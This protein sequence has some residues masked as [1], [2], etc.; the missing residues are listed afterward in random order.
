MRRRVVLLIYRMLLRSSSRSFSSRSML[1]S[2]SVS[3]SASMA[4]R[5]PSVSA[6]RAMSILA[7]VF[8]SR[9]TVR[10]PWIWAYTC[11][12]LGGRLGQPAA[13]QGVVLP[14]SYRP[15]SAPVLDVEHRLG[16]DP[17]VEAVEHAFD[18]YA[19]AALACHAHAA[20][21][22]SRTARSLSASPSVRPAM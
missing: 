11:V 21:S 6:S 7:W 14:A 15:P 5:T 16:G 9:Q 17:C 13:E 18:F 19:V 8:S 22:L 2:L 12:L 3:S 4:M 20:A 1:T 10:P